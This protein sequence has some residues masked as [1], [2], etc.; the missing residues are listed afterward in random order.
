[1]RKL[2]ILFLLTFWIG[3]LLA[4]EVEVTGIITDPT[5]NPLVGVSVTIKDQAGFGTTSNED[6]HYQ[7]KTD[8]YS[9]LL[10]SYVGYK[11][12]EIKVG[13]KSLVNVVMQPE[14][15]SIMDQVII[16]A[17]GAKKKLHL[18]AR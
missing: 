16:T 18:Q 2:L 1:M 12:Q 6:G 3:S 17:I 15:S 11:T 4:Q 13:Q 5:S 8:A 7:I 9:I 10:F 14:D